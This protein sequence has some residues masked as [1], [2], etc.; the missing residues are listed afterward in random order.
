MR[1]T[2]K[3]QVVM[4]ILWNANKSLCISDMVNI[5][6]SLQKNSTSILLKRML[7]KN[8]VY[9]NEIKKNKKALTQYYKP[10]FS[11]EDF[12]LS[13]LSKKNAFQFASAF[14]KNCS[15]MN[16]LEHLEKLIEDK[17]DKS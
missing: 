14:I 15:S 9:I 13:T 16:E 3:E 12:L 6:K 5:D 4:E 7:D 1:L 11:Q 10:A 8:L 17:K 2:K